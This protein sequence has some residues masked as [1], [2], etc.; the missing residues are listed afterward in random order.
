MRGFMIVFTLAGAPA[1]D[2]DRWLG[3]DKAKHFFTSAFVQSMSYGS[4]RAAGAAH[5]PALGGATAATVAAGAGKEVWDLR[6]GGTPSVKDLVWD[7]AGAGA[8]TVLLVRA[9]R[10]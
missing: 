4:L 10:D 3:A 6:G 7:A 1:G 2:G 5:G 9:R 8:A